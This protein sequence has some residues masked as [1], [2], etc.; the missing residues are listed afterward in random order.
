MCNIREFYKV[1][2]KLTKLSYNIL[3]DA[4]DQFKECSLLLV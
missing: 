1:D 4:L 3:L 2:V